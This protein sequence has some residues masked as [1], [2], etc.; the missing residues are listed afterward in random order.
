VFRTLPD[1]VPLASVVSLSGVARGLMAQEACSTA[2]ASA[3]GQI[4]GFPSLREPYCHPGP[5][6][7]ESPESIL[8][9]RRQG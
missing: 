4:D 2:I 5:P 6:S 7:A 8:F 3:M 9:W 1:S